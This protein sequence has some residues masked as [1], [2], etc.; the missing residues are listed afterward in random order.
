MD[1]KMDCSGEIK[2]F[3]D[4]LNRAENFY[5]FCKENQRNEENLTQDLLHKIELENLSRSELSKMMTK[6]KTCRK[7]RRYFKDRCEELEDLIELLSDSQGQSF[8]N[9]LKNVLGQVR[10]NE[11]YHKSRTYIPK[12]LKEGEEKR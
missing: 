8:E 2:K 11:N 6:L 3:L 5:T 10:K 9:K 4:F 7:E 1:Y 12:V